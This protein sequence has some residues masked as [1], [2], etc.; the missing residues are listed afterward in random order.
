MTTSEVVD[1][2]SPVDIVRD[3]FERVLNQRDP[4]ALAE[5]WAEDIVEEF[6][7]GVYRGKSA[8]RGYFAETF[9]A[10]PDFH[11]EARSIVGEGDRVF[12]RWHMSGTFSGEPWMGIE[13]TGT[14]IELDGIDCFSMKNG[15]VVENFVV[16]DQ[17]SF[18][19]QIG[20]LPAHGSTVDRAM[21]A[22]FNLRTRMKRRARAASGSR[23]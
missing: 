14:R 2:R 9:A 11:I 1:S 13:A 6:P 16:F 21:L 8:V 17:L 18:A 4:D 20:M 19:R 10:L 7:V 22:A 23:R 15:R 3:V 12:V 5:Y